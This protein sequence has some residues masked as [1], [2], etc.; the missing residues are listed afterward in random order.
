MAKKVAVDLDPQG[1]VTFERTLKIP[2]PSGKVLEIVFTFLHRDREQYAALMEQWR[3]RGD[4]A[5]DTLA[6]PEGDAA[7]DIVGNT[8]KLLEIEVDSFMDTVTDWNIDGFGFSRENVV[9]FLRRYPGASR[10][11]IGDYSVGMNEGR[12]GN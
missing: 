12:L 5:K 2:T 10:T 3:E 7:A 9:R 11:V 8:K 4:A 1:P 6:Q